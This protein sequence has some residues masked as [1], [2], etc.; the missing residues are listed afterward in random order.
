MKTTPKDFFLWAAAMIAL[1][2]SVFSFVSLMFE[3]INRAFPDP[4]L[5]Y[6]VDPYSG[7]IRFAIASLAVLFPVFLGLMY[8]IRRDIARTAEKKDLWVRR[9]ALHLTLFVAGA[10]IVI[11]LV[12]LLNTYLGGDLTMRFGLKVLIVLLIAVGGFLHF[13]ADLRG[14]WIAAP[15]K[16][17]MIGLGAGLLV[18]ITIASGFFIMGTPAQV[19]LY[20]IDAEKTSQLQ[21]I[22]WQIVNYWQ[23][24]EKLPVALSELNDEI[25]GYRVPVDPET[26]EAY[27]YELV[28][29]LS[30]KLCATFNAESQ[31]V[32]QADLVRPVPGGDLMSDSWWHEAGE[33]C[34]T[35][36]ID[37]TR[38]P[39]Y[40]TK[41]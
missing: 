29:P 35:R 23:Q 5:D 9:W 41:P 11:D 24:Q 1:Y 3:Y 27:V 36:T 30:F 22:Q 40:P 14:Y 39:T 4:A 20:R 37:P 28:S 38:Y 26:G 25:S 21:D 6:Y 31:N 2:V 34:F 13:L 7:V 32:N 16:A 33:Q 8:V 17:T 12:T 10:T 18:V 19:R 15:K